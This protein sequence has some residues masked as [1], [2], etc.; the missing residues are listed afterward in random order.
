MA[1]FAL[2]GLSVLEAMMVSYLSDLDAAWE[3][4]RNRKAADQSRKAADEPVE[5]QLDDVCLPGRFSQEL[6]EHAA[7]SP[8][9]NQNCVLP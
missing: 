6:E 3:A 1:V 7:V 5:I 2:V 8:D 9:Q 4:Y